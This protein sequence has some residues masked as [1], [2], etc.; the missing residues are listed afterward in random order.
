MR[1]V[2]KLYDGYEGPQLSYEVQHKRLM[3]VI[4]NELTPI[5]R[6]IL[7]AYYIEEKSSTQIA[8]D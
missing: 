7:V 5:Q 3:R 1:K 2:E 8:Q 6:E 4:N